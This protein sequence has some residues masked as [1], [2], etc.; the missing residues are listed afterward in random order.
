[1][2]LFTRVDMQM[3]TAEQPKW[4]QA[5]YQH[6]HETVT[7]S[8]YPCYLGTQA[9]K[10]GEVVYS[11]IDDDRSHLPQT[12]R[13]TIR[14]NRN[15]KGAPLTLALFFKPRSLEKSLE[16]YKKRFWDTLQ[17]L[18]EKDLQ[19]WP[20]DQPLDPDEH[21]WFFCFHGTPFVVFAAT[22][23]YKKRKSRNLG[24]GM[25]IFFQPISLF[26]AFMPGNPIGVKVRSN[27][28][29]KLKAYDEVP[30]HPALGDEQ[31]YLEHPWK[32][33]FLP[34]EDEPVTGKCPFR[35]KGR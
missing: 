34:D 3:G 4:F 24:A 19:P 18:H 12:I 29:R 35:P 23:M 26:S 10:N 2:K 7:D 16:D 17:Y 27:I 9:E 33:F 28:R 15:R 6:F 13:T 22:P 21:M 14:W 5:A 32:H 8:R 30:V 25:V 11:Y 1:M 20:E 31:G